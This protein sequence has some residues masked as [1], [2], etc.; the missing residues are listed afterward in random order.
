MRIEVITL[1]PELIEAHLRVGL[2]GKAVEAG[3]LT[4]AAISPRD[5]ATDRHRSVDDAP[6]GGGSGMVMTPGPLLG[7]LEQLDAKR[8]AP[9][10]RI[11]MT[12]QGRLFRQ[13][14]AYRLAMLQS[15][16]L[17]CG[18]YEG[19][20]ERVHEAMD[21]ELSIGDYVLFGGEVAAMAVI[22]AV[23]R[24]VPGVL[25]NAES[26]EEESHSRG[27]LEYPHYTR[28][29]VFREKAVPDILLS[30]DHEAIAAWRREAALRR[31]RERRP[32]LLAE[33][34]LDERERALLRAIEE[35]ERDE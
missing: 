14:D 16:T 29:R 27:L 24:L 20:D 7:A 30:G 15:I 3:L 9:T 19:I 22:E 35:S 6:Y 2:L 21:E 33:A 13:R 8:H 32:D 28:P 23:A 18:R 26:L 25:G 12:P 31:T 5:F 11:L 1:F 10:R 34:P 4:T 17:V